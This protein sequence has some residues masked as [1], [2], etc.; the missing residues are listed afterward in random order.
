MDRAA[1]LVADL[2]DPRCAAGPL[3]FGA[4]RGG[5]AGRG[6]SAGK[7]YHDWAGAR[8]GRTSDTGIAAE[9]IPPGAFVADIIANPLVTPLMAAAAVRGL[10]TLGGLGMLVRQGAASF[11]HW[12]GRAGPIDV[13][14]AAARRGDGSSRLRLRPARE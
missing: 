13:M 4:G 14:F 6:R 1:A 7:L 11:Q 9:A 5:G 12:T 2:N 8:R 3:P 10:R